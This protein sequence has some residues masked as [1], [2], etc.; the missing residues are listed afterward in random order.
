MKVEE[1]ASKR[2]SDKSVSSKLNEEF[3]KSDWKKELKEGMTTGSVMVS[4]VDGSEDNPTEV[5][6]INTTTA[7]SNSISI[8]MSP[9]NAYINSN[10]TFIDNTPMNLNKSIIFFMI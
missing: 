1:I 9:V 10:N 8:L 4:T 2:K 3:I 5:T 6:D 7:G